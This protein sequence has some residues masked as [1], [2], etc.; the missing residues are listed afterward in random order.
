MAPINFLEKT[1]KNVEVD[2]DTTGL[3]FQFSPPPSFHSQK[4]PAKPATTT[5]TMTTTTTTTKTR[6]AGKD[7]DG[8]DDHNNN[9]REEDDNNDDN[10]NNENVNNNH[11]DD[12]DD[13][14]DNNNDDNNDDDG[15]SGDHDDQEEEKIVPRRQLVEFFFRKNQSFGPKMGQM[16]ALELER[17]QQVFKI[18]FKIVFENVNFFSKIVIGQTGL[19]ENCH[20]QTVVN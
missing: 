5:V 4:I 13:D 7:K 3:Q 15:V 17:Q 18:G 20:K 14:D 12:D 9:H 10:D 16:G 1:K 6:A 8:T 2:L 19:G 11:H